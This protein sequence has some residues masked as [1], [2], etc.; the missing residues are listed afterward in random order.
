MEELQSCHSEAHTLLYGTNPL[1]RQRLDPSLFGKCK[2][3]L[4][5][6]SKN[7]KINL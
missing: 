1:N 2:K 5:Q 3:I 6:L 7:K 4:S